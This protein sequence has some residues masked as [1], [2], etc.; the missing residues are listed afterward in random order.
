MNSSDDHPD[1]IARPPL[2]YAGAVLAV[3]LLRWVWP[4]PMTHTTFAYVAGAALIVLGFAFGIPGRIALAKASTHVDP[5]R[6]TTT[7]VQTSSYRFSRNP[8]YVGLTVVFIG[9]GLIANTAWVFVILIPLSIAMH[10]GVI[11]REEDYLERKFG[12]PYRRYR[13]RVRRYL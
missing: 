8:L 9:M 3:F 13:E 4:L 12:E 2:I 6:P 10:I 7:V 11:L 1:I 5:M